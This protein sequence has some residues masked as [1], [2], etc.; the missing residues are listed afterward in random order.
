VK[1]AESEHGA[2]VTPVPISAYRPPNA[3]VA[4][5]RDVPSNTRH[6]G[7]GIASFVIACVSAVLIFILLLV[8]GVIESSTPG[9]MDENSPVTI[10]IGLLAIVFVFLSL[11]G[12]GLGIAGLFQSERRKVFAVLGTVFG[13]VTVLGTAA[14]IAVGMSMQ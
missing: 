12:L 3:Y 9:G 8:A 4:D 5:P 14:I 7:F 13:L 1:P 6:S 10:A 2:S 11:V